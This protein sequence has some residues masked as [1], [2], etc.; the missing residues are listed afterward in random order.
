MNANQG[1]NAYTIIETLHKSKQF[2]VYKARNYFSGRIVTIKT[3]EYSFAGNQVL[4]QQLRSEAETGRRLRHPNI[5]ETIGLFEDGGSAYMVC[6]Y[7]EGDPLDH[8]LAIPK[9]DISYSQALK[10]TLQILDALQYA[11][12]LLTLHLNLQ[13]SKIM[14]TTDYE[15][16]L[17]GFGRSPHAWKNAEPGGQEFHPV[18]F[19]APEIFLEQ[20]PDQRSDIYSIGV[21]A[22]LLFTGRLPWEIDKGQPPSSQKQE[23]FSKPPVNQALG[24]KQIPSW[25]LSILGKALQIDPRRRFASAQE[26]REAIIRQEEVSIDVF[27]GEP[28]RIPPLRDDAPA[29][30]EAVTQP[31]LPRTQKPKTAAPPSQ[32]ESVIERFRKIK[33]KKSTKK[34]VNLSPEVLKLRKNFKIMAAIS[35]V[36]LIYILFK[37]VI[38][39]EKSFF[40]GIIE[41]VGKKELQVVVNKA[42]NMVPING[43]TAVMGNVV[44]GASSDEYPL[45]QLTLQPFMVGVSEVTKEEWAMVIP[46]K[47]YR[48]AEKD[49][50]IT[51]VTF[52]EVLA[53]CNK[54]SVLDGLE[55]CYEFYSNGVNCDFSATGYRLPTEAEWEF[56]AKAGRQNDYF[57]FSG[58]NSAEPIAWFY[59]N[60]G[61]TLQA[62]KQK[63]PNQ[64]GIYDLSGNAS[65]WVWNWYAP[66]SQSTDMPFTG[67]D[68]GTDKVVRGGSFKSQPEELRVTRREYAKP[69]AK[70]DEIGFRVV[71]KR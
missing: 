43:G 52:D 23:L 38:L 47:D 33:E 14:I 46:S 48:D 50:P 12:N 15:L 60:S 55:P 56:V 29:R 40:K 58:S 70:E 28:V 17:F 31:G 64:Y 8:I 10:W 22:Y 11:H 41:N 59:G 27:S 39:S 34:P 9:V 49:L 37:Y 19:T 2:R 5:R 71:R 26:M 51:G 13:P 53:W 4:L 3:N 57:V 16:K 66:Y 36:I 62:V 69:Y 68:S 35:A 25:L 54:K 1:E 67:P 61:G 30:D 20:N 63:Q 45:L 44:Q 42:I 65:E 24:G 18:I 21:L 32:R 7:L 6:E